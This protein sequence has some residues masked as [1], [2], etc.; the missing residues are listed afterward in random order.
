MDFSAETY[1]NEYLPD[2]GHEV[3][4]IVTVT[5]HGNGPP[6]TME[7]AEIIIVDMSGSM[8]HPRVKLE[9]AKG[10][11]CVAVDRLRD[12]VRFGVIAG[13]ETA[14]WIYPSTG[15]LA[16]VSS[17]SRFEA[18]VQ[19]NRL[20]SGGGTAIGRWLSAA[21]HQF[22]RHEGA[23]WHAILLT[24]GRNEGETRA[25]LENALAE[26]EGIFQCDCRGVGTD[27]EVKELREIATRL[28]GTVEIIP[29]PDGMA[30]DFDAMMR[31]AMGKHTADV[32]LRLW[33]PRGASIGF[34]KQVSPHV[35]DLT[36]RAVRADDRTVDYPTG[37]WGDETRD[38]HLSIAVAPG[39][40]GD[41]MLAGRVSLVVDDRVVSESLVRAIWTD[42]V[43]VSTRINA[44]VANYTG[45]AELASAIAEGLE[46]RRD[47]DEVTATNRFERAAQLAV[48]TRNDATL[49][50]LARV[51][52]IDAV[53]GTVRL[54]H[55]VELAD[56]MA[57]DTG[58]I[59]TVRVGTD[60]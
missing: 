33:T 60:H 26:C 4:A 17:Q 21:R 56:E 46:A 58:S 55:R 39:D 22:T 57:L 52:E 29:K 1:Q 50:L 10:A 16:V 14:R 24:D 5:G 59:K 25:D 40:V 49:A 6:G 45:Q 2:G 20:Q 30:A 8:G 44:Q 53:S 43:A 36:D 27:W 54:K 35:V 9:A 38:Y 47:G 7:G 48:E 11:T 15:D 42:D 18:K 19:I 37:A 28:L 41:V 31:T 32:R 34:V 51:V 3:N 12:G 13:S 23:I